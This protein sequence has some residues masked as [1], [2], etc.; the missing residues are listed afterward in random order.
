MKLI[1]NEILSNLELADLVPME[2]LSDLLDSIYD[3]SG[4]RVSIST[5]TGQRII[6]RQDLQNPICQMVQSDPELYKLCVRCTLQGGRIA[7]ERRGPYLYRCFA[8]MVVVAIPVFVE[9]RFLASLVTSGF[10][11]EEEY[12]NQL[13]QLCAD[14]SHL[15]PA[16]ALTKAPFV[17]SQR[18]LD[19]ANLLMVAARYLAEAGLRNLTQARL[20]EKELQLMDQLRVQT[21]MENLLSQAEFK[22][23]QSQ[24]NPHFL[25]NTLNTIS[26]LAI[27]E[28][29]NKTA[30]AIFSLAAL[31][32]RSLH[33]NDNFPL[34]REEIDYIKDYLHIKKLM[35][36]DRIRFQFDVDETCLDLRIPLFTLQ[37]LVENA[38]LHGLEPKEE[39]GLLS[40][41]IKRD[42]AGIIIHISDNGMGCDYE[43][44]RNIRR[45][46]EVRN[47]TDLTGLGFSNAIQ[48]LQDYFGGNFR[49]DIH[50]VPGEG[51]Q[52]TLYIPV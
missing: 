36:G 44:L 20:H 42:E 32:R 52:I 40:L 28:D 3:I 19:T 25:F 29:A 2:A 33:K 4:V 34:L 11:V 24:I 37:P 45:L 30:D 46:Q 41:S 1:E 15:A 27:L 49:W 5:N 16:D 18:A 51:T 17:H 38:L 21:D 14:E 35:Y 31:L 10:R 12:Q 9:D 26:Q 48:R 13:R 39:G 23:L 8:G 22:V 50:S 6:S 47:I 7:A 43:T